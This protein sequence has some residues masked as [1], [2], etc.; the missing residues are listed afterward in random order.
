MNKISLIILVP[1]SV[2]SISQ[3]KTISTDSIYAYNEVDIKPEFKG[4]GLP[5]LI[6]L[7][8]KDLKVPDSIGQKRTIIIRFVI[9]KDG[10]VSN[11]KVLRDI[12]QGSGEELIRVLQKSPKWLPGK[13]DGK[14]V[15]TMFALPYRIKLER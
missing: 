15:R 2:N 12:G 9:E 1:F 13:K 10:Q 8:E 6:S 5:R 4:G 3:E 14:I 11:F 7:I